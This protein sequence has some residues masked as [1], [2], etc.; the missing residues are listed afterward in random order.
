MTHVFRGAF[1][2][3]DGVSIDECSTPFT[4]WL[5]GDGT[6]VMCDS[7]GLAEIKALTKGGGDESSQIF[8]V[9]QY[10]SEASARGGSSRTVHLLAEKEAEKEENYRGR[11]FV[12]DYAGDAVWEGDFRMGVLEDTEPHNGDVFALTLES[13]PRALAQELWDYN[14]RDEEKCRHWG[15]SLE[16]CDTESEELGENM[17]CLGRHNLLDMRP[18]HDTNHTAYFFSPGW[19]WFEAAERL[20]LAA[21]EVVEQERQRY[22][23]WRDTSRIVQS[24]L[25]YGPGPRWPINL[26]HAAALAESRMVIQKQ[27]A[28]SN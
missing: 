4:L 22:L 17:R 12:A 27:D 5:E 21:P 19:L 1:Q 9:K 20:G 18:L 25:G 2:T 16:Y 3:N 11:F 8:L 13:G 10:G 23:E 28:V 26:Q 24:D 7:Y 6:G 14:M 15:S